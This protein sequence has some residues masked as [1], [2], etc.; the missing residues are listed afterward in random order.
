MRLLTAFLALFLSLA[1]A[2]ADAL[3][4]E[5]TDTARSSRVVPYK[6]Y[7]PNTQ[8]PSPI[9]IFSHGLGGNR[10]GAEY[11]LAYLAEHGYV[12]VAVQH[13]G[14]DTPAVFSGGTF[15]QSGVRN[16]TSASAA[17][18]RFRDIPFALDMLEAMNANDARLKGR[19][20]M[21]RIGMSG[22]SYG[23]ITTMALS[24]QGFGPAGRMSFD[25]ARIKASIV[26]SPSKPRQ[27]DPA[28]VLA[29]IRI[30]MFHMTGTNDQNPLD[31]SEPASSRQIPYRNLTGADKYLLVFNG[32]DHMIFSGRSFQGGPRPNDPRLHAW[33]QKASLA[34]WDAYLK[35][36]ADAKTY[37]TGGKFKTELGA[38]GTF[39]FQLR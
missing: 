37:L 39:E 29:G 14:S 20:D 34:F 19:M 11:L 9:V 21:S 28:Q 1:T 33:I 27:G 4:G 23:A 5:W 32:G 22:H 35:G 38:E 26:Y 25:D 7:L 17:A 31:P 10:D 16:A 36:N 18:D 3:L 6:I 15:N 13:A 12:A 2:H 30:P 24:G 8:T